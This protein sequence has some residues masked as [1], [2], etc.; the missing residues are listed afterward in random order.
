M[1]AQK[2]VSSAKT[3]LLS[4]QVKCNSYVFVLKKQKMTKSSVYEP[5]Q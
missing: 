4:V 1:E 2:K 3:I 5:M